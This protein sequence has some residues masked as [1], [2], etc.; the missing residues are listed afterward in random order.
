MLKRDD[1]AWV[2]LVAE[3]QA[4]VSSKDKDGIGF[5]SL[6]RCDQRDFFTVSGFF[7]HYSDQ[8]LTDT[9][10]AVIRD[11]VLDGKPQDKWLDGVFDEAVLERRKVDG[12]KA[13]VGSRG[14]HF[15]EMDG[16]SQGWADLS[17]AAKLQYIARDAA[18]CDVPFQAFAEAAKDVIG[19]KPDAA[20]QVVLEYQKELHGL[21]QL[22]PDDG[23]LEPTP[24]IERF[25]EI[26]EYVSDLETQNKERQQGR[27][28]LLDGISDA[29]DG[30]LPERWLEGAKTLHDILHGDHPKQQE[31]KTQ[32]RGG[33][34]I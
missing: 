24:L 12:F 18:L 1:P 21:G 5:G 19:D 6:H 8:G 20:L 7:D 15:E 11:N 31:V 10:I 23:R 28:K 30:K 9:Q 3:I 25:K 16:S 4:V 27:E 26:L 17:A 34:D 2:E 33:K 22:L 13:M 32:E 14:Y 29:L